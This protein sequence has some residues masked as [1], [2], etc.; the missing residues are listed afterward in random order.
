[1]LAPIA[2]K[3]SFAPASVS[4]KFAEL[5][6]AMTLRPSRIRATASD[7]ALMVPAAIA[8]SQR[9]GELDLPII[10]VAGEGDLIARAG[11]HAEPF[12]K[13]VD[14]ADLRIVDGAG[15]LFH[16]AVPS[17]VVAA[18]RDVQRPRG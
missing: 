8:L 6:V 4:R 9:F 14:G 18:I 1:M 13:E 16:Y 17:Q 2:V 3:V 15:H 5:P 11:E 7:T 12:A 10:V